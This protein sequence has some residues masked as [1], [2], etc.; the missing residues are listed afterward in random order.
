MEFANQYPAIAYCLDKITLVNACKDLDADKPQKF[1]GL[2]L[3]F[4]TQPEFFWN[5][6]NLFDEKSNVR[7]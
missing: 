7:K 4:Q 1:T 2:L 3:K 6:M 5:A